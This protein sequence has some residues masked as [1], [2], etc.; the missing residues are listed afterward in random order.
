MMQG[1]FDSSAQSLENESNYDITLHMYPIWT[2]SDTKY[3]YVEQSV[4]SNQAKPYRQRVYKVV[5]KSMVL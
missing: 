3:L 2:G 5:P 4:T 1:S